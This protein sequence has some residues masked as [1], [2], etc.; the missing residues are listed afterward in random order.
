[1]NT[2]VRVRFAPSPTGKLHIGAVRTALYAY[3]LAKQQKG[4]FILR[5]EDTDKAREVEGAL[6]NIQESLKWLGLD[7][8]E[9]YVQSEHLSIYREHGEALI[10]KGLAYADPYTPEQ[11]EDFRKQ[12][13]SSKQ[14]FLYRNFRPE[15]PPEWDGKQ[16]LRFKADPQP[17][18]WEDVVRGKLSA[19]AE[20]IDDIIL[21][22]SDGYPTYNFAHIVDDHLMKI[23]HVLRGDEFIAS[24]PNYLAI[25]AAFGWN[26]PRYVTVPVIL[27]SDGNKKLSKREGAQDVLA[28]RESGY[29]PAALNN[30]LALLGWNNGTEQEIF[31]MAELIENFSLER[32]QKS[33]A[34]FDPER[35]NWISAQHLRKLTLEELYVYSGDFWP[36]QAKSTDAQLRKRVLN[37]ER[38]RIKNLGELR[39]LPDYFFSPPELNNQLAKAAGDFL[40]D[41]NELALGDWLKEVAE[42][43][44]EVGDSDRQKL[45]AQLRQLIG[46]HNLKPGKLFAVLRIALTAAD[47]TP[48][49]WDL[50]YILGKNESV[51]R[52]D[53]ARAML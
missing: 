9:Q 46:S 45:E 44:K 30:F 41:N 47:Q 20:S 24:V 11:V 2:P 8:D 51:K 38:E 12:A 43:I 17:F 5:I 27:G 49:I 7:W 48:P 19:G 18:H 16:P 25:H 35:L 39:D 40:E 31:T 29:L 23:S 21:I 22:K 1:M 50:V 28:Y 42:L 52:L 53:R 36:P 3:L 34:Q 26:P 15:H 6:E 32:I 10:Q 4:T 14:P 37:V 33:P 13:A